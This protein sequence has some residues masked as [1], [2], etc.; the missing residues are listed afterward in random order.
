M[1]SGRPAFVEADVVRG[2]LRADKTLPGSIH[3]RAPLGKGG[4]GEFSAHGKAFDIQP[5]PSGDWEVSWGSQLG[6]GPGPDGW[7]MGAV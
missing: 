1:Y 5:D 6:T 7:T 3:V 2:Y 4:F